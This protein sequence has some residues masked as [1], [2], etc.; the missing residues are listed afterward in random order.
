MRAVS[1]TTARESITLT[2]GAMIAGVLVVG[3]LVFF[4]GRLIRKGISN[5]AQN[6]STRD[7][8]PESFAKSF[9]MAFDNNGYFGT[10][11][12]RV[13]KTMQ[14]IPTQGFFE[15]VKSAYSQEYSKNL[16]QDLENEL[17]SSEYEEILAIERAKPVS[18][19]KAD[20]RKAYARQLYY[21]AKRLNEAVNYTVA[22]L[23]GRD[24]EAIEAVLREIPTQRVYRAVEQVYP[25]M[26]GGHSLSNDLKGYRPWKYYGYM[27]IIQAKP[28]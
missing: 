22:F 14:A 7:G 5:H 3:G 23:P 15:Q 6:Q 27:K 20:L 10:D 9:K 8:S 25:N 11:V 1:Y 12:P 2:P 26:S 18:L 19:S 4:I 16:M 24:S 13:R 17:T 28:L 21:W